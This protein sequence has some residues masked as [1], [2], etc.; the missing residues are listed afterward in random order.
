MD[1]FNFA[2]Q[3]KKQG[4]IKHLGFSSHANVEY[5]ENILKQHPE[6]EFIQLQINY[7]TGKMRGLNPRNVMKLQENMINQ[8]LSWKRKRVD[9]L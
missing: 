2:L 8:L 7:L 5:I 9:S 4:K 1:S 6:M 3:K